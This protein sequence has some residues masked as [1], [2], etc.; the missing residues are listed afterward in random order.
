LPADDF[1]VELVSLPPPGEQRDEDEERGFFEFNRRDWLMFAVG[2]GVVAFAGLSVYG[3]S[4]LMRRKD[5]QSE[6]PAPNEDAKKDETPKEQ[7]P[8]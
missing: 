5:T 7:P 3:I 6:P 1:D 8:E 4:Q 2:G